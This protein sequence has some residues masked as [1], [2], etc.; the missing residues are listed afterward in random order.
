GILSNVANKFLMAG[1]SA[2]DQSWRRVA[3]VRPANDFKSM[4]IYRLTDDT[5][6]QPIGPGG[7]LR[8][9]TLGEA[10]YTLRAG[11]Y[12]R[13]LSITRE[14]LVNDDL[15]A[16]T[17]VP[18]KLGRG[19]ATRFNLN[20]WTALLAN[21]GN[22][23]HANNSNYVTGATTV[24]SVSAMDAVVAAFY[25]L[26]DEAGNPLGHTPRI[27]LHPPELDGVAQNI[28]Q[29]AEY[30]D[31]TASKN[32][33]TKNVYAGRFEPVM[34]PYLSNANISGYSTTAWYLLADPMDVPCM[35]VC[36]LRGREEPIVET[37]DA[38]FSTLGINMRAYHDFGASLAEPRCGIKSKGAA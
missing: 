5:M 22:F 34:S 12:G 16:L 19:C 26:V 2:I 33:G 13:L 27:L 37:A 11:T 35:N 7:E 10:S 29:S 15:G 17:E 18:M 30:R 4:T 6:A 25:K 38:D 9:G 23:F 20:F 3:H 36:F 8:H 24:L 21:T 28:S 14:Q 32:F 31:T 1:F